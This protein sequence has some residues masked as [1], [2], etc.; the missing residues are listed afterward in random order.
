MPAGDPEFVHGL[1]LARSNE[2]DDPLPAEVEVGCGLA[3][4][5]VAVH[6][7]KGGIRRASANVQIMVKSE[8]RR[9]YDKR[10]R[11]S[12]H[13]KA[14]DAAWR[15]LLCFSCNTALGLVDES[16][17]TLQAMTDYLLKHL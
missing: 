8:Q 16:L 17:A 1:E 12:A 4:R 9:A 5:H 11:E 15:G 2:L 13:G 3:H 6:R 14:V 7:D 10:Y